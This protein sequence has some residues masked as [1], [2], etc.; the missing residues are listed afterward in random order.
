MSEDYEET[1]DRINNSWDKTIMERNKL[2]RKLAS[3]SKILTEQEQLENFFYRNLFDGYSMLD[4]TTPNPD[5]LSCTI[6][7]DKHNR[8]YIVV[9]GTRRKFHTTIIRKLTKIGCEAIDLNP[10]PSEDDNTDHQPKH[11][12]CIFRYQDK[13]VQ[14][15]YDHDERY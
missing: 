6:L 9:H 3:A 15:S 13:N 10:E 11:S 12:E 8:I 1:I 4:D 7:S 2:K 14:V 5:F